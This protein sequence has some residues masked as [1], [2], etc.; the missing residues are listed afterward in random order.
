MCY[1]SVSLGYGAPVFQVSN[2]DEA[3]IDFL[4]VIRH[5]QIKYLHLFTRQHGGDPTVSFMHTSVCE[6]MPTLVVLVTYTIFAA[7]CQIFV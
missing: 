2:L 4:Y 6:Y 7:R 1:M 5:T 3:T